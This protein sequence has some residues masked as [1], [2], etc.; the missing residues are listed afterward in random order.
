MSRVAELAA[1]RDGL[2][3][4]SAALRQQ[5]QVQT[6]ELA[7]ACSR[8][9]RGIGVAR[10]LS[11][12][13]MMLAAGAALLYT[14]GPAKAFRWISRGLLVTSVV[15]RGLALYSALRPAR[16]AYDDHHLFV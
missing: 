10:R 5:L 2:L 13:P 6:E 15:R 9:D 3:L 8:I 16:T 11:S 1:R 7:Q 4:R 14:L 12:R